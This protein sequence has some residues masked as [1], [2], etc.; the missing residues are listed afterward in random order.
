MLPLP[1]PPRSRIPTAR[2]EGRNAVPRELARPGAGR[3]ARQAEGERG[4]EAAAARRAGA[5]A[6]GCNQLGGLG[7]RGERAAA[8]RP[9]P[10]P[11][12]PAAPRRAGGKGRERSAWS[13]TGDEGLSNGRV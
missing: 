11:L 3:P 8:P 7:P 2:G 1:P 9:P 6:A 10:G 13:Q 4:E 12:G 5:A